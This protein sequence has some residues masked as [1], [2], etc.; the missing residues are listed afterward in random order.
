LDQNQKRRFALLNPLQHLDSDLLRGNEDDALSRWGRDQI[1]V[2]RSGP[3][4]LT[5][6][7]TKATGRE[8]R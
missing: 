3:K 2:D 6:S 1:E 5:N 8:S 7:P 4:A